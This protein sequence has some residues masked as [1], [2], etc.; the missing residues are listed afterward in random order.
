MGSCSNKI[1]NFQKKA[2]RILTNSRYHEHT[3]PVLNAYGLL[4]VQDIFYSK[5]LKFNYNLSYSLLPPYLRT[6]FMFLNDNTDIHP[7]YHLRPTIRPLFKYPKV[8][9][10]IAKFSFIST[11]FTT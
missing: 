9:H 1:A 4:M 2:I 3:E 8:D 10:V 6:Y 7:T 5:Q 11:R